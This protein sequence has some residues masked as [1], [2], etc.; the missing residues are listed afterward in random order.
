MGAGT[1][2]PFYTK[3]KSWEGSN[4][5]HQDA[6]RCIIL[7]YAIAVALELEIEFPLIAHALEQ[8][9]GVQRRLEVKGEKQ[10]I[11][12][13]DDYGHH[14]TEIRATLDAVRDGWPDRRLVVVFQP[15]RYTRTQGLLRSLQRRFIE[16]MSLS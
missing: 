6:I 14:P 3:V 8:F 9:E 10:G 1:S 4:G 2:L 15:H 16:Q 7:W 11:L 13:V 5:I 12:V